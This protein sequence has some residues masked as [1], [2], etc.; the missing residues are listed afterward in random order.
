MRRRHR[1]DL[2]IWL[3][4]L[5]VAALEF[6]ISFVPIPAGVRPIL[7]LPA[8]LMAALVALGYMRLL[9]APDIA[10]GFAIAGIFWLT[11]LLGL[12][13]TDPLTRTVYAAVG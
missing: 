9:T 3:A 13:M 1:L 2:L 11:I 12:A 7:M 4:L 8:A 5:I 10:R 6:G